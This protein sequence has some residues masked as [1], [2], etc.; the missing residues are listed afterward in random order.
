M[1]SFML[2]KR[3]YTRVAGGKEVPVENTFRDYRPVEGIPFAFTV[4]TNFAGRVNEIQFDVI[5]L[6]KKVEEER[7]GMPE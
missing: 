4:E 7:F 1:K 2:L 3:I 5:E 6:D